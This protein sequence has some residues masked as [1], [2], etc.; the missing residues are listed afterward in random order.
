[1][2]ATDTAGCSDFVVGLL[3]L[4]GFTYAPQL[5]DLPDQKMWRIDRTASPR[6][7]ATTS[8]CSAGTP[9]CSLTSPA[10]CARAR[11]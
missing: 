9:S 6:S 7:P 2:I 5:A 3:G 8:T 4:A 11:P 1:M 10:A